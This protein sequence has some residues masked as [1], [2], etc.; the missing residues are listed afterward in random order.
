MAFDVASVRGLFPTLGDGWIHFDAGAGLQIPDA[1]ASAMS[2]GVRALPVDPSGV[3]PQAEAA[4]DA[5]RTARRAVADLTGADPAGVVL[6]PS[7]SAL[8]TA[9]SDALPASDWTG[10]VICSRLDD[11][12]TIVP[13]LRGARA[14]GASVR[15]AEIDVSDGTLPAWQYGD[16]VTG[17]T[18][19][20]AV[21][22]ASS[23]TGAIVDVAQIANY[24]HSSGALLVVDASAVAPYARM[25]IGELGADVLLVSPERWGG[26][27]MAAMAFA[28]PDRIER[29]GRVSMDP[30]STGP[31]RLEAEPMAGPLLAGLVASVEHLAGLDG[32]A[33]GKRRQRLTTSLEAA[34]EYGQRLTQ[35][36]INSLIHLGR[37]RVIGDDAHRIPVV[38]IVVEGVTAAAVCR[39]LAD[40]G[41]SAQC[42][43]PSR[44][45]ARIG[46]S[47]A[48]GAVTIGLGPYALPY[49]IDQL[50]RVLG[51][52]G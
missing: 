15:W 12:A 34:Y 48:G 11:E 27:R 1:V 29:L 39:R 14:H 7:R 3:G 20:V 10:E 47:E 17:R 25:S 9:L 43:V 51:S 45:L 32:A 2:T 5:E 33:A 50:A 19:I 18:K 26:P 44:A 21:T 42:D 13:W 41:I 37:V 36:L 49:E 30:G 8:V 22:L 4:A 35:Y 28:E 52:F 24:A 46:A 31:A 6:G 16:L 23:V 38:S 40:N